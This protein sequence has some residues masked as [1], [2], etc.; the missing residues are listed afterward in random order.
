MTAMAMGS[1]TQSLPL[2]PEKIRQT[3]RQ[4][5]YIARVGG[6][7]F[8]VLLL[9]NQEEDAVKVADKIR[10]GVAQTSAGVPFGEN[11]KTTCSIGIAPLGDKL[12]SIDELLQKLHLSLHFSKSEG[13]DA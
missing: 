10:L 2:L 8:I 3:V 13:K 11:V 9:D 1:G 7:E 6:D 5:D 4:T 12:A